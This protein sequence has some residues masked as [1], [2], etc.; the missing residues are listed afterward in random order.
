MDTA[1]LPPFVPFSELRSRGWSRA[2]V[3]QALDDG[4]LVW[5]RRGWYAVPRTAVDGPAWEQAR[6]EHLHRLDLELRRRPG[7]AASHTS[8]ALVHGLSLSI[9]PEAPLDLTAVRRSQTSRREPGLTLHKSASDLADVHHVDGRLVT[10]LSRTV[11][12]FLRMRTLPHGV[13][14]LDD[15]L[16]RQLI[17]IVGVR[18]ELDRQVRWRGR[19]RALGVLALADPARESWAESYTFANLHLRGIPLPLHQVEILDEDGTFLGRV[20]GLWPQ[21][22]VVGE[23]DGQGKYFI[24]P[25]DR[26]PEQVVLGNLAAERARQGAMEARGLTFVRWSPSE[27]RDDPDEVVRRIRSAFYDGGPTR[28]TGYAVWRGE[29]RQLPFEVETPSVEADTLRHRRARRRPR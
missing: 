16:R 20:D 14:L 18:R 10:T 28:F 25:E 17:D 8:A 11:A 23:C 7:H 3:E 22:G 15:A 9:S 21:V 12:D 19:P 27:V 2:A 24:G 13:A 26:S 5:L 1:E 6:T 4:D 29:A